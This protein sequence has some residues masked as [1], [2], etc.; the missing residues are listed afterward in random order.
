MPHLG[1][2]PTKTFVIL[3]LYSQLP[4]SLKENLFTSTSRGFILFNWAKWRGWWV[5]L[6]LILRMTSHQFAD[7]TVCSVGRRPDCHLIGFSPLTCSVILKTGGQIVDCHD[8]GA[9]RFLP[10]QVTVRAELA[11]IMRQFA[12]LLFG[13]MEN[14]PSAF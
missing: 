3:A 8:P 13:V 9:T 1:Q 7:A 11:F 2:T 5:S 12:S 14:S 4:T 10:A 6:S